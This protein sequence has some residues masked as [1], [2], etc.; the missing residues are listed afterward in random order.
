MRGA[1]YE[2]APDR[3]RLIPLGE[4]DQ[5]WPW[6]LVEDPSAW[7]EVS[8]AHY[9]YALEVLP[10]LD[11]RDGGFLLGEP[12]T[13]DHRGVTVWARFQAAGGRWWCRCIPR[14]LQ[15]DAVAGLRALLAEGVAS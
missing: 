10:P 7:V 14:D 13:D 9:H 4:D 5:R 1:I 3:V 12:Q 2:T 11:W 8:E 15:A 6:P